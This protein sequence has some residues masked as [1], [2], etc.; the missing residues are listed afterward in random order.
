MVSSAH[1]STNVAM[2][3]V[4][5]F[6]D[7]FGV[8]TPV[9]PIPHR[10]SSIEPTSSH[11]SINLDKATDSDTPTDSPSDSDPELDHFENLETGTEPDGTSPGADEPIHEIESPVA[12]IFSYWSL[13]SKLK[14]Q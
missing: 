5:Y 12:S 1:K 10:P 6:L 2:Y 3:A 8:L 9:T 13:R 7:Y 14:F 4:A 11:A